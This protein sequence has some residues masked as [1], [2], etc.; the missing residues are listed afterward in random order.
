MKISLRTFILFVCASIVVLILGVFLVQSQRLLGSVFGH[1][2]QIHADTVTEAARSLLQARQFS[3][4]TYSALLEN[5]NELSSGLIVAREQKKAAPFIAKIE[6]IKLSTQTDLLDIVYVNGVPTLE[7]DLT[8]SFPLFK[9]SLKGTSGITLLTLRNEPYLVSYSPLRNYGE[10]VGVLVLGYALNGKLAETISKATNTAISFTTSPGASARKVELLSLEGTP[11]TLGMN[12][13]SSIITDLSSETRQ[14][15]TLLGLVSLFVL[16][17]LVFLLIDLGFVRGFRTVLASINRMAVDLD[18]G[19]IREEQAKKHRIAE[20][21]L[22]S[23]A[24]SK[25]SQSL[26]GFSEKIQ[27]KSRKEAFVEVAEQVAHD[28]KSPLSALDMM[29]LPEN[30]ASLPENRRNRIQQ[31]LQRIKDIIKVMSERKRAEAQ[32]LPADGNSP[33]SVELLSSLIEGIVAE[34]RHQYR[35]SGVR[36]DA[37]LEETGIFAAVPASEFKRALSNLIDNAVQSIEGAGKVTVKV[38]RSESESEPG[39]ITISITDSGKGIPPELIPKLGERGF[40]HGKKNGSGLGLWNAREILKRCDGDLEVKSELGRGTSV[41]LFLP[42]AETPS[43][44]LSQL[45]LPEG[46]RTL[47][48]IDDEPSIHE[49]WKQRLQELQLPVELLCFYSA[50]KFSIWMEKE[51]ARLESLFFLFDFEFLGQKHSGIELI[52]K[53]NLAARSVLLTSHFENPLVQNRCR[54]LGIK[55]LPKELSGFIS[56][57]TGESKS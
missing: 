12:M 21:S 53:H 40:T 55:L 14:N 56:I 23:S 41:T 34:K 28:L 13:S 37:K 7:P 48:L 3:L 24:F 30:L 32:S 38:P 20:V 45:N 25:F 19:I 10:T 16:F 44:F 22:L 52:E 31:C 46:V 49:L 54:E 57:R 36:L 35:N 29:L 33:L 2:N 4:R 9:A 51:K 17:V 47:V 50:E 43:W 15:I 11:L 42:R 27:T 39:L 1:L 6:K 5:D 8:A 18:R 26:K